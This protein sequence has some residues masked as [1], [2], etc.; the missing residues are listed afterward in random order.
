M[1]LSIILPARNEESLIRKTLKDITDF[2]DKNKFDYEILVVINGTTDKTLEIVKKESLNNKKIK[3]LESEPGYGKA[4][5]K[6]LQSAKGKY[7]VVFNVDF[8]DLRMIDLV[9]VD[10]CGKDMVIGSKMAPWSF[11]K[12]R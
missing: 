2:L 11:D 1:L 8:Y 9:K 12:R 7:L 6:G 4:L 5:I 10:L 3:V